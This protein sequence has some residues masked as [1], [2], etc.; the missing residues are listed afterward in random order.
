VSDGKF[1]ELLISPL[2]EPTRSRWWPIVGGVLVGVGV[3]AAIFMLTGDD[4][5]SD[6]SPPTSEA[7]A[8]PSTTVRVTT[9]APVE[10]EASP[11]PAGYDPASD[12]D[13]FKPHHVVRVGDRLVVSMTTSY[14]RGLDPETEPWFLGGTWVLDTASGEPIESDG[15]IFADGI[16]GGFSVVFTV[17]EGT[18][19]QPE[20]LRLVERWE[21]VS[22]SAMVTIPIDG[23]SYH[24]DES[25]TVKL[26]EF[27]LRFDT[28]E[29]QQIGGGDMAWTLE[30]DPQPRGIV[31]VEIEMLGPDGSHIASTEQASRPAR[32]FGFDATT[33]LIGFGIVPGRLVLNTAEDNDAF[34]DEL[35]QV[36]KL[37]V[38]ATVTIAN[39]VPI[40][41]VSF[42][43]TFL[44]VQNG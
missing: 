30:G 33:G 8:L 35:R 28:L 37:V 2:E 22:S 14:A 43:L 38:T 29:I 13:A 44:P 9:M 31:S 32:T 21:P 4:V 19:M 24:L 5:T 42:D 23:I 15:T 1:D 3:A 25:L 16:P 20:Q 10:V 17:P 18:D 40:D 26:E 41:E 6:E 34:S 36:E 27:A 12:S 7:I 11:F 39:P